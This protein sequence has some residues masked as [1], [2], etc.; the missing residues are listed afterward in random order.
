[1]TLFTHLLEM[2]TLTPPAVLT[3]LARAGITVLDVQKR[4]QQ[5]YVFG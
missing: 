1:M 2:E 3:R 4:G 5:R